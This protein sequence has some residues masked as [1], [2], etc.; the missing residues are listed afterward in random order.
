MNKIL[1]VSNDKFYIKN[2]KFYNSNKNTFTIINSLKKI[3]KI[4]LVAR[5]TKLKTAFNKKF[6]NV[7]IINLS[8]LFLKIN[9]F[10]DTKILVI[11]LTP[12]NFFVSIMLLI[13]GAKKKNFFL[14]LRSDGFIEY[15]VKFGIVG[16]YLYGLMFYFLKNKLKI[17]SCSKSI[18]GNFRSKLVFPSEI[19]NKWLLN[20]IARIQN[21]KDKL[22]KLLYV[23]RFREEKGYLSLIELHRKL[24]NNLKLIMVG[25]DEKYLKKKNFPRNKNLKILGQITKEQELIK[26]YDRCDIMI[27]PSYIEA[28]PQVILESLSR[29]KPIIIFNEIKHLKK[30]FKYG[31]ISCNRDKKSFERTVKKVMQNYSN[32]QKSIFNERIYTKQ[33]FFIEME[34]LFLV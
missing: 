8:S 5:K 33:S 21:K 25:N 17:L 2:K 22:V 18:T 3:K 19:S 4:Y 9:N 30:T 16:Y 12:Y 31:L 10:R 14:F 1:I 27:L 15:K 7:N 28:Y 24:S 26:F 29:L 32:I 11:S 23:G 6:N 34:K 20:R 13:L